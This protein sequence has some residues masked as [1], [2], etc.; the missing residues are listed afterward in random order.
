M[1][2]TAAPTPAALPLEEAIADLESTIADSGCDATTGTTGRAVTAASPP[3]HP[4]QT[5]APSAALQPYQEQLVS[6]F[7]HS[8]GNEIIF[9]PTGLGAAA[10][11]DAAAARSLARHTSKHVIVC[12][13]R[14]AQALTHADRLRSSLGVPVAA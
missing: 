5:A 2:T 9:L 3:A 14:P 6:E 8:P 10:V 4:P 12:V 13:V 11:V 7:M 1:E